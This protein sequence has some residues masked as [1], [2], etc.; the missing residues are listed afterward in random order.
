MKINSE[1][2]Y[3]NT[4]TIQD[5]DLRPLYE[6][7]GWISYTEQI[8]DLSTLV[9]NSQLVISAWDNEQLVGL[10]RTVGDGI[11]IQYVQDILVLPEYQNK[12][13]G[14]KL[15]KKVMEASKQIRQFVL[16]TDGSDE[17]Q[18]AIEFYKK[19][20]LQTFEEKPQIC[21]LWRVI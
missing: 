20:G 1:I 5:F 12:G 15:L 6:A 17:N 19:H 13:I 9:T 3:K 7:V 4:K 14:S 21:G 10:I 8:A 16:I 11:S 2:T 18:A